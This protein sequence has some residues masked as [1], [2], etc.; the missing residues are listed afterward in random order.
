ML[1]SVKVFSEQELKSRCEILIDNYTKTVIIE[2]TTMTYMVSKQILPAIETFLGEIAKVAAD[3]KAAG[4]KVSMAYEK[5]ILTRL[6]DLAENILKSEKELSEIIPKIKAIADATEKA[7][8]IRDYLL[9]AMNKLRA[10]CD[11]A[12]TITADKYWPFP[13]YS[14]LPF[15]V[16]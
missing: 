10:Y 14:D 8:N 11:E 1:T 3:K 12:E 6:S 9:P 15:S 2:A 5:E 7:Y 16:R 4:L 13:T